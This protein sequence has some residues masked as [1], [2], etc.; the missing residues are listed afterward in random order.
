MQC[1]TEPNAE[2]FSQVSVFGPTLVPLYRGSVSVSKLPS[3]SGKKA[4]GT[5]LASLCCHSVI[6]RG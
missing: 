6:E 1:G 5:M 3:V 4:S 2:S